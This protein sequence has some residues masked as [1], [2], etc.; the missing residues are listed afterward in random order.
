[1]ADNFLLK[2]AG[3]DFLIL[4]T[5]FRLDE[6]LVALVAAK[7]MMPP[8]KLTCSAAHPLVQRRAPPALSSRKNVRG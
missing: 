2:D 4:R 8:G 6:M 3:V 1:L 7:C 5:F